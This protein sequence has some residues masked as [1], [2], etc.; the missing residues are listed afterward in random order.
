[1]FF[2]GVESG[3]IYSEMLGLMAQ[4][5]VP[6]GASTADRNDKLDLVNFILTHFNIREEEMITVHAPLT[7]LA[8][9]CMLHEAKEREKASD[10]V[11]SIQ[12]DMTG[13]VLA[14]LA[15]LLELVPDRAFSVDSGKDL[16]SNVAART[17][18]TTAN[19][20]IL[21]KIKAF[22]LNEQGNLEAAPPP[23]VP[24]DVARLLLQKACLFGC[25]SLNEKEFGQDLAVKSRILLLLL[26]KIPHT[27]EFSV[28]DL[29]S[30]LHLCLS[31]QN[32]LPFNT[33]SSALSLSAHLHSTN[34][35]ATDQ[36]SELVEP[37]V[38]HAWAYLSASE[39]KYHVE[40]VRNLWVLQTALN[41]QNRDIEA[42]IC[43]LMLKKDTR[44]I[45]ASR[46]AEAGRSFTVLWTHSLQDNP[47]GA[48]RRG[49]KTPNGDL[50]MLPRL[51]GQDNYD[52]ML[53]RP[54]LLMLDALSDNR[55][56]LFMTAK[57]W[58][59]SLI[60]TDK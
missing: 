25:A 50:K 1:V 22:Y 13:K 51:A 42:A 32:L 45:F 35:I 20:E 47:S 24:Q 30:A 12:A 39:P 56:Q 53:T 60:G 36:L 40:T 33:F 43:S 54:L 26:A 57:H 38:R 16:A 37:L 29:L 4:A 3:L 46:P 6:G 15:E 52:V 44:G 8:V 5:I 7:V 17:L 18:E 9:L 14:V 19:L 55:A 49:P 34:R 2:D 48:D 31:S 58:L 41:P 28:D 10:S 11:Q 27:I 59:H 23:F 21:K